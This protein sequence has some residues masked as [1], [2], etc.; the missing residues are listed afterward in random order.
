MERSR[1]GGYALVGGLLALLLSLWVPLLP[2]STVSAATVLPTGFTDTEWVSGLNRPYQ[3]EF[4]PDGRLF[5]SQQGGKLRVIKNG[6]LLPTPFLTVPVDSTGDRGLIGIAF[7][8]AFSSNHFVYVYYTAATPVSHNRVSRFTANGDVAVAGSEQVLIEL[9]DLGTSTLHNGGSIHFG[10]DGKLYI[11]TGD[12]V[13]GAVAQ[14]LTSLLGKVLRLNPDGSI[15]ADNPFA[16]T[17]SGTFRAIWAVGMRNPFTF[18]IQP[19]TGRIFLDDVGAMTWE[20]IDEGSAGANYGWPTTEGPT[21][22]PRFVSPLF[23]YNHGSTA[24]TGCAIA[25]GTFY[26][27]A[28]EEFPATYV[29]KYFFGDACGGWIHVLDPATKTADQFLSAGVGVIDVKVGPDGNLYYLSRL[30]ATNNPGIVHKITFSG[31]PA[32]ESDP[33]RSEERRVG[34]E[35]RSRWSPYH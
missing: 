18:G 17:A 19:G 29:G 2:S 9:T 3:M 15:P 5:V 26:N 1:L 22:D 31:K 16:S 11:S 28:I 35:C 13:Q 8:P 34:K 21:S 14:S 23:A 25:G 27:P 24:T 32:I 20:E 7:D 12:N 6:V 4:A 10:I 30:N 33:V